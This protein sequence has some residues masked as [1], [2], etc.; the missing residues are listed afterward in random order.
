MERQS[1]AFENND[2]NIVTIKYS[3][4]NTNIR[5]NVCEI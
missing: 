2:N 3:A 4:F 5:L 1:K